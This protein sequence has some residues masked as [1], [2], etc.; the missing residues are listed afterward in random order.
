MSE[1]IHGIPLYQICLDCELVHDAPA[2]LTYADENAMQDRIQELE[3]ELAHEKD[4][5]SEA[6]KNSQKLEMFLSGVAVGTHCIVP[7]EPTD[8][9]I[10][11]GISTR[12][13]QDVPEAWS[14][15]TINIYRAMIKAAKEN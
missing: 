15:A 9:M 5:Y 11:E 1:C 2:S 6:V 3:A 14:L 4:M 13:M 7:V 10:C 12:H 8:R